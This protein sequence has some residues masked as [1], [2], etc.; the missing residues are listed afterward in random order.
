MLHDPTKYPDPE[1]FNQERFLTPSG[2]FKEDPDLTVAFG[3]GRRS[4]KS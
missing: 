2:Q 1:S 3:F 4:V